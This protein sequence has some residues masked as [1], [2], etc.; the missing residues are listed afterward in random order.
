VS[1][2]IVTVR[3]PGTATITATQSGSVAFKAAIPVEQVLTVERASQQITF[4]LLRSASVT[5]GSF[6]LGASSSSGLPVSYHS[7]NPAVATI[8]ANKVIIVGT[9]STDISATQAG[10]VN[11]D[12][13][14]P[15]VRLLEIRKR[16]QTIT[17][18]DF[19]PRTVNDIPFA[20]DASASSG[21]HVTYTSSNPAVARVDGNMV[22]ITGAGEANIT[23][24]QEGNEDFEA[25]APVTRK[26]VVILI[27]DLT[28]NPAAE[29][30]SI[31]PNPVSAWLNVS[32]PGTATSHPVKVRITDLYGRTVLEQRFGTGTHVFQINVE[33]L[34]DGLYF[35]Q[36]L[37][38][39]R[40]NEGRFVKQ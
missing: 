9:G 6:Y 20:L 1:G 33:Q 35:F 12:A 40:V 34:S 27:T 16:I 23:A 37:E 21:L 7:S 30:I 28:K 29:A 24:T 5:D 18:A 11:Y 22:T 3:S 31:Y 19:S 14:T 39:N 4:G 2:R 13:A 8:S 15:V 36:C 25:A 32:L 17:F 26:L 38:G 10:N